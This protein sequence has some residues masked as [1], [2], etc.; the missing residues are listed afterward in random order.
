MKT[1]MKTLNLKRKKEK[2]NLLKVRFFGQ[3]NRYYSYMIRVKRQ[4]HNNVNEN[5]KNLRLIDK[6]LPISL[7]HD[8]IIKHM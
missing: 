2:G 7:S 5:R 6:N 8:R 4:K 3:D 1:V